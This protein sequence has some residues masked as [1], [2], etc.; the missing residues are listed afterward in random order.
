MARIWMEG[1][2]DGLPHGQYL[3]GGKVQQFKDLML[4][5]F[6]YG[7]IN[8]RNPDTYARGYTVIDTGRSLGGKSLKL[9]WLSS[10]PVG[11][12]ATY[13]EHYTQKVFESAKSEIYFRT[14]FKWDK[15]LFNH[16]FAR[17]IILK[18]A[19]NLNLCSIGFKS[20]VASSCEAECYD[21]GGNKT[22]EFTLA[23]G[24]WAMIEVHYKAGAG[25]GVFEVKINGVSIVSHTNINNASHSVS[26]ISFGFSQSNAAE[27]EGWNLKDN[28]YFD[29]MA[30]NDVSGAINN[31][32]CGAGTI[33]A[34]KPKAAGNKSQWDLSQGWALAEASSNTTTLNITGHGLS[35]DDV[36]YNV[37]RDAYRIITRTSD[38]QFTVATVT[39]QVAGDKIILLKY[40]NTIAAG[41]GTS[42]SRLVLAGHTLVSYDVTVNTSR[43]NAIKRAIY[44][45]GA[46]IYN[47]YADNYDYP[48]SVTA[49]QVANDSIKT[50]KVL[51]YAISDHYKAVNS[52]IPHPQYSNIQ[53]STS[54]D[55]DTFDMEELVADKALP[56]STTIIAVS[57][58]M[59]AQEAGG[60]SQL[61]P[62]FRISGADYEGSVINLSGGTLEYQ[63]IYDVSP[64]TSS[65]FSRAEIDGLEV[66]VKLV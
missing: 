15:Q 28:M 48:G 11:L 63:S 40:A 16:T 49:S 23:Q 37:T 7:V 8:S 42:T 65:A 19:A 31:S 50:F 64:A 14:Y 43:S 6:P 4:S 30:V 25:T 66:G 47:Y 41:V 29:D 24:T 9:Y 32:W 36:M 58:N 54:N 18:N 17:F 5:E 10:A 51:P 35:T 26:S 60:G 52:T 56:A 55:I 46:N 12:T 61:K 27:P 62:V 57:V 2:E 33:I 20:Q 39:G 59:Y 1:F 34:L 45:D 22:Q 3:E 38:N 13:F 53:S 21:T 44:T